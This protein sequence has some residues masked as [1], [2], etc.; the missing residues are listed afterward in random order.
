MKSLRT[1]LFGGLAAIGVLA[2]ALYFLFSDIVTNDYATL[3]DAKRDEVFG[4]GWLPNIL[5]TSATSIRTS[6][7]LDINTSEGQF[8]FDSR[9]AQIFFGQLRP[10][11]RTDNPFADYSKKLR[12]MEAKGYTAYEFSNDYSVW[13]FLCDSKKGHCVYDMWPK[14]NG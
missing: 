6:N 10:Y 7:N 2:L 3:A 12:R 1:I 5:P 14:R 9:D 13:V 4:R 11:S 8:Y